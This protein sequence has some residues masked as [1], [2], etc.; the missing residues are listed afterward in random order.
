MCYTY[1]ERGK[2]DNINLR[3]I[4]DKKYIQAGD[5]TEDFYIWAINYLLRKTNNKILVTQIKR[6]LKGIEKALE[7]LE[8]E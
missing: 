8:K 3:A 2:M 1:N 7:K 6:H 5:T 4:Y